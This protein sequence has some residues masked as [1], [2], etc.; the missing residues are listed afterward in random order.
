LLARWPSATR[1][2]STRTIVA[3]SLVVA[4]CRVAG[5]RSVV[6]PEVCA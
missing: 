3:L 5:A 4:F 6:V 2:T 1:A